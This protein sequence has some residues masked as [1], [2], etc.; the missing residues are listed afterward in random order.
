MLVVIVQLSRYKW[1]I[2]SA[3][4]KVLADDIFVNNAREASVYVENWVSSFLGW[5]FEV[6]P[7]EE[8]W[9]T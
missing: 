2:E 7:L 9:N 8:R 4:G 3:D 5:S 6:R 1:R